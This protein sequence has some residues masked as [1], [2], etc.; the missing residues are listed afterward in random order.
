MN[1]LLE[2]CTTT[3]LGSSGNLQ[4]SADIAISEN[5]LNEPKEE[6]KRSLN[7]SLQEDKDRLAMLTGRKWKPG[8]I[9]NISFLNGK[10]SIWHKVK[11]YAKE[12]EKYAN[13]T[14][15]FVSDKSGDIRIAFGLN[16]RSYSKVGTDAKMV[17]INDHT[18]H[19]GWLDDGTPEDKFRRVVVHEFGHALG[20]IHEHQNP[21]TN[22]PWDKEAVY[23]YYKTHSGWNKAD[24]DHNLFTTYSKTETNYSEFDKFSIMVYSI[25]NELTIGDFEVP[26]NSKLSETDKKFASIFYPLEHPKSMLETLRVGSRGVQTT[27]LQAGLT[28]LGY[29]LGSTDGIFGTKTADAVKKYQRDKELTVDGIVGNNT[30]SSLLSSMKQ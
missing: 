21:T 8:R 19:F 15:N 23:E 3:E 30:W 1:K 13:I 17:P 25:P 5:S 11:E 9:L 26:W 14:L 22:I 28:I 29:S 6:T 20:L 27:F 2:V 4:R 12:W 16:T 18:M 10:E 7:L 24:V